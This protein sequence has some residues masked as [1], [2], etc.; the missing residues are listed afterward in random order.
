MCTPRHFDSAGEFPVASSPGCLYQN[1]EWIAKIVVVAVLSP[2]PVPGVTV[3]GG[4][5]MEGDS[6]NTALERSPVSPDGSPSRK[7]KKTIHEQSG[8]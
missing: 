8:S 2:L 5:N 7:K 3:C 4:R 6:H 1:G